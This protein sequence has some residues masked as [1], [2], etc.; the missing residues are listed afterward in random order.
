[1]VFG[2]AP[3]TSQ[4]GPHVP[5]ILKDDALPIP[6]LLSQNSSLF[7]LSIGG[8]TNKKMYEF[9]EGSPTS[10]P[11][12][13]ISLIF[14]CTIAVTGRLVSRRISAAK[15]WWDDVLSTISLVEILEVGAVCFC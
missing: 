11:P 4:K 2:R 8:I 9:Y 1:M 15:F 14:L 12:C 10:F 7:I 5:V 3:C 6:T 13:S